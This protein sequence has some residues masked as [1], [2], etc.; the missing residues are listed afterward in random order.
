MQG[1]ADEVGFDPVNGLFLPDHIPV[2][3]RM[4]NIS[5]KERTDKS[6]PFFIKNNLAIGVVRFIN[7][8]FQVPALCVDPAHGDKGF[9]CHLG[10]IHDPQGAGIPGGDTGHIQTGT[11]AHV[12]GIGP[13]GGHGFFPGGRIMG[14]GHIPCRKGILH[15]ARGE[16]VCQDAFINGDGAAPDTFRVG[17][18]TLAHA[19]HPAGDLCSIV[20]GHGAHTVGIG[21]HMVGAAPGH[22]L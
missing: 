13:K 8:G 12:N 7:M 5:D 9:L 2:H 4:G 16:G 11:D 17:D 20:Q 14:H 19:N 18:H 15:A 3:P 6:G 22:D 10:R 21:D 1:V